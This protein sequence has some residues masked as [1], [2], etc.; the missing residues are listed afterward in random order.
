MRS[1]L[2]GDVVIIGAGAAGLAAAVELAEAGRRV[3]LLEARD[4]LGGRILTHHD[5]PDLPPIELG[6]EFVHGEHVV[7]WA[8]LR[9]A[10]LATEELPERRDDGRR[11]RFPDVYGALA[12]LLKRDANC[13]H[14][15]RPF[16]D[17]LRERRAAGDDP[18]TLDAVTRF[19]EGFHAADLS[20]IGTAGL[21]ANDETEEEDG[22]RQFRLR[23]GYDGLVRALEARVRRAG[24]EVR[25]GA[26]VTSVAWRSGVIAVE[27]RAP[28]GTRTTLRARR[29]VA[30]LPLGV[31][32]AP[33][34]A[35]G[36][37]RFAPE[38]EAWRAALA[39][40]EMG[41]AARVVLR[42]DAP[43]WNDSGARPSFIHGAGES[44]P[45]WWTRLPY[46]APIIT[47]WAGGP[48]G[49]A[50]AGLEHAAVVDRALVSLAAVFGRSAEELTRRL[51]GAYHHD[52]SMDPFAR[53]AYSYGGVGA[54]AARAL[55]RRPVENT[56]Y[57]AG[58]ALVDGRNGTV[59]AALADGRRAAREMLEREAI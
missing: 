24:G 15:D 27:T 41:P 53:G 56:L 8:Y 58:E 31:L 29:V 9:A 40:L 3:L 6:A 34:E 36:A 1:E 13:G 35:A 32:R 12:K 54:H 30:T 37:V 59:H 22:Q 18:D 26:V 49:A 42:F 39:C 51:R 47:G 28:D 16:G 23:S 21:R 44:F 43:W 38:P 10:G 48:A 11:A 7:T 52:W 55:L 2:D 45:V 14:A 5:G 57:L 25:L 17:L 4:R 33:A 20:R 19:V 50:L 46:E